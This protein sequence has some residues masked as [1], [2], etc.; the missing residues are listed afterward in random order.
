MAQALEYLH[1]RCEQQVVHGDTKALNV[2][3]DA[4]IVR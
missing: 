1:E 2:L 3:L 4:T